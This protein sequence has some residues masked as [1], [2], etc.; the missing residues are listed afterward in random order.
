MS[1]LKNQAV[2]SAKWTTARTLVTSLT[3][4]ILLVIKTNYLTPAE[5]GIMAIIN[6]FVSL[7]AVFENFGFNTAIIR[8]DVVT[9]DERSS[10][11][12]LQLVVSVL[13]AFLLVVSSPLLGDVFDMGRLDSLLPILSL[14]IIFNSPV[15][16][17]TAFLEKE[18]HFKELSIIQIIRELTLLVSTTIFF[19]F[20][21][22]DLL[23]VVIGQIVAVGV[24]AI[25]IIAVSFKNDLLHLRFHF[26]FEDVKP[27]F[28]FGVAVAAKQLL[29]Q[30][31]HNVD[32]MIIGLFLDEAILGFYHFA[33][34]LLNKFRQIL[35]NS[36][37]KILLPILSKVKNDR[38]RLF[39][40]YNQISLYIA[41]VTLPI[42]IGIALTT[43]SFIP[44]L[45]DKK[46][47]SSSNF[48]IILAVSY[49]PYLI[50]PTIGTNL[51]Y[52]I[53]KPKLAF[54]IDFVNNVSYIL[55]LIIFS[56]LEVGIYPVVILYGVYML[57]KS[58][59]IQYYVY[60]EFDKSII[61]Y[62]LLFKGLLIC[63][64][65][66]IVAVLGVQFILPD[67]IDPIIELTLSVITGASV[68][69]GSLYMIERK[70]FIDLVQMVTNRF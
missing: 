36:F 22:D 53:N 14:S 66:M 65:A 13:L 23:A 17:F 24:M 51:L 50:S 33:K 34:N 67:S 7:I 48:F 60:K 32:E 47:L 69:I 6:I 28:K 55:S 64:I 18:F 57:A 5:F 62:F 31:T 35:T 37:S 1:S 29:I 4:P 52:S 9:K 46:W 27:F 45:F 39:R 41:T 12:I 10:L 21:V 3:G 56:W 54:V 19:Q 30:I 58:I 40:G 38:A 26:N 63:T 49:I 8:K 44:V 15:T 70:I 25:L 11:F 59:S 42:F 68:Y 20:F 43:N 61:D 2:S 16:L